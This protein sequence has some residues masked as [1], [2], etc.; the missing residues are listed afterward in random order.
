MIEVINPAGNADFLI[1]CE[2]ASYFMP[3]ELNNLGL[4]G[5]ILKSHIAWDPGALSIAASMSVTLDAP[6]IAHRISRLVYD[7]NRPLDAES[8]IPAK[9]EIFDVPGNTN[10]TNAERRERY[11]RFYVPFHE[12]LAERIQQKM[13]QGRPPTLVTVH[14]FTP[15]YEGHIRDVEIGVL[16][17]TDSR[18]ADSFLDTT[19]REKAFT[20]RRNAP[21]GPED[22]VTHTLAK[23][24]IPNGLLNVMFEIRNDLIVDESRQHEIANW[25]SNNLLT[26]RAALGDGGG[27]NSQT[28]TNR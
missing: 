19:H 26:A 22:G 24:A 8:A 4:A 28:G 6:L 20:I 7:C 14:S 18:L 15:I 23:H 21:Y 16:H 1:A 9:S 27:L 17:D 5:D 13:R 11:D 12:V 3:P 2:H 25:I 10:L